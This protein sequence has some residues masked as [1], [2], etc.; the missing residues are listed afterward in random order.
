MLSANVQS[1]SVNVQRRRD[2]LG[3]IDVGTRGACT[4]SF[5]ALLAGWQALPGIFSEASLLEAEFQFGVVEAVYEYAFL[6][7][8]SYELGASI[9]LHYTTLDSSLK[10]TV[11]TP[12]ATAQ[13]FALSIDQYDGSLQD[14]RVLVTW[15][16]KTWLGVGLG[17]NQFSVDL[18]IDATS[19]NGSLDWTYRGPMIY[20]SVSF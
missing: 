19:F 12:D 9:G 6:R 13:Y 18:D 7:R 16:P 8:D 10:A 4:W 17:Y 11:A 2:L 20:Y 14:Y 1:E 15:Q 5:D 3:V